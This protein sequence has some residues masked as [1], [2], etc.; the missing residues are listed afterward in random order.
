[1][2][3]RINIIDIDLM[4]PECAVSMSYE[5]AWVY[6][7]MFPIIIATVLIVFY[8]IT[9]QSSNPFGTAK[10]RAAARDPDK[11]R[12][13]LT[14]ENKNASAWSFI[15]EIRSTKTHVLLFDEL[16]NSEWYLDPADAVQYMDFS[17]RSIR[18]WK[19]NLGQSSSA[20]KWIK[21]KLNSNP[22]SR[23]MLSQ[24]ERC[25]ADTSTSQN[26]NLLRGDISISPTLNKI[27]KMDI[28]APV[29]LK[30]VKRDVH[31]TTIRLAGYEF[32]ESNIRS[33][34]NCLASVK[35]DGTIELGKKLA[36]QFKLDEDIA[37]N[38]NEFV[39]KNILLDIDGPNSTTTDKYTLALKVSITR[40]R[41]DCPTENDA[42]IAEENVVVYG[43]GILNIKFKDR[44]FI[45]HYYK[46]DYWILVEP[47]TAH[48]T[49]P[50]VKAGQWFWRHANRD[51]RS[52]EYLCAQAQ[53][54]TEGVDAMDFGANTSTRFIPLRSGMKIEGINNWK[55]WESLRCA[56]KQQEFI[57]IQ[58][59]PLRYGT[60]V[61][62]YTTPT[63]AFQ[64]RGKYPNVRHFIAGESSLTTKS[65][66]MRD[67]KKK[68]GSITK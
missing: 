53:L 21:I 57:E 56:A 60:L 8:V 38:V 55:E 50:N 28:K 23:K 13:W 4:S 37:S 59:D 17:K 36:C 47:L 52:K 40:S 49:G 39:L 2:L 12:M 65:Q 68:T 24:I 16:D 26:F 46:A 11:R 18:L 51:T 14:F 31:A 10:Q 61:R 64:V 7:M 41:H 5:E 54:D 30:R 1:M 15:N 34:G 32:D 67:E 44:C 27:F 62:C 43:P 3:K 66:T 6:Y 45:S 29:P 22:N 48:M 42:I 25:R 35:K 9:S 20:Q 63:F 33:D 58:K 19:R